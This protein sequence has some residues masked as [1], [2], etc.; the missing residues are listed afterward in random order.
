MLSYI[1]DLTA[2]TPP[3]H[4]NPPS[5]K[6]KKKKEEEEEEKRGVRGLFSLSQ[7]GWNTD[8]ICS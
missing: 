6:K 4:L 5:K 3:H 1:S 2:K 8:S 7:K